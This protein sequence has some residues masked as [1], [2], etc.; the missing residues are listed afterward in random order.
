[1]KAQSQLIIL[2]SLL[3]TLKID[4][5]ESAPELEGLPDLEDEDVQKAAKKIQIAFRSKMKNQKAR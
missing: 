2:V 4:T 3:L 1:M 5:D